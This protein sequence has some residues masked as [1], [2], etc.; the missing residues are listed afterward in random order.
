VLIVSEERG[1]ISLA[2]S[3]KI[4]KISTPGSLES[5]IETFLSVQSGEDTKLS[6]PGRLLRNIWPKLA[7]LALVSVCW[8][9]V[10]AR[11]GEI[12][13]I[14]VPVKYRNLPENLFLSKTS[15]D[16]VE[17]QVKT[18]SSLIQPPKQGDVFA[19]IDLS[20]VKEGSALLDLERQN[21]QLPTGV[22]VT[23]IKPEA[24]KVVIDKR[25][26]KTVRLEARLTGTPARGLRVKKFKSDPASVLI[27]GPASVISRYDSLPVEEIDV[28]GLSRSSTFERTIAVSYPVKLVSDGI[29]KI[30]V[31]IG[32]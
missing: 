9:I 30:R 25:L 17:V 26:R 12:A 11:Q 1:E 6:L 2:V 13:T 14:T 27:E 4:E 20:K 19:E 21:I 22:V 29:V 28:S 18:L 3:G 24:I 5:L 10:T 7:T 31:I 8:L 15:I 23:R 32:R 16:Q